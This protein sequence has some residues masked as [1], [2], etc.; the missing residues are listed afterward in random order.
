MMQGLEKIASLLKLYKLK[1]S[2]YVDKQPNDTSARYLSFENAVIKWYISILEFQARVVS[3]LWKGSFQQ[4]ARNTVKTEDF[5]GKLDDIMKAD[6]E[7]LLFTNLLDKEKDDRTRGQQ[8]MQLEQ[9]TKLQQGIV[10]ALDTTRKDRVAD[11]DVEQGNKLMH[12]LSNDYGDHKNFNPKRVPGTCEWFLH[13]KE[14]LEWRDATDSRLLWVS[15]GP[16][17]G[18]SVLSRCLI[19]ERHVCPRTRDSTTCY[20]FFRDGQAERETGPNAL[21]AISHQLLKQRPR[22]NLVRYLLPRFEV[23]GDKLGGM[24]SEL[25]DSMLEILSDPTTGEVVWILDALDECTESERERL[26]ECLTEIYS[27]EAYQNNKNIKL[28]TL[29]TSRQYHDIEMRFRRLRGLAGYIQ[30]DGDEKSHEIRQEI[31]LVIEYAV[32]R[33][34]SSLSEDDQEKV[35]EHLRNIPHRTYLWLHLILKEI[36]HKIVAYSTERRIASTIKKLPTSV[37]EAYER[38]LERSTDQQSARKILQIMIAA[39]RAL[40]VS[41]MNVALALALQDRCS[42]YDALDRPSD[43]EFKSSVKQI[44]GLFISVVDQKVYLLH[45]TAR[46]FLLCQPELAS[47]GWQQSLSLDSAHSLLFRI[48][49]YLLSFSEVEISPFDISDPVYSR[50]IW[51]EMYPLWLDGQVFL[52]YAAEAWVEHYHQMEEK[53]AKDLIEVGLELCSTSLKKPKFWWPM[54]MN[55][56]SPPSENIHVACGIGWHAVVE[57]MVIDGVDVN[58]RTHEGKRCPLHMAACSD[59]NYAVVKLLVDWGADVNAEDGSGRR[60]LHSACSNNALRVAELLL[61]NGADVDAASDFGTAL[62][63]ACTHNSEGMV[64]LLLGRGA[65]INLGDSDMNFPLVVACQ[66]GN[67]MIA[68]HLINHGADINVVDPSYGTALTTACSY[69]KEAIVRLLLQNEADI[70]TTRGTRR[71]T[72]L[73]KACYSEHESIVRTPVATHPPPDSPPTARAGCCESNALPTSGRC[74]VRKPGACR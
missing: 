70:E 23:H 10:E 71:P 11:Y 20:F 47:H 28:K 48:C 17:C 37:Y 67:V 46:E 12:S 19:D 59:Q 38:I 60:P 30:L 4:V 16:G 1:V 57:R 42:S 26:L 2:L 43:Q 3:H 58:L 8:Y 49:V 21:K 9:Q 15:A 62:C 63:D 13:S 68:Q 35:I 64:Q 56:R 24:F 73:L 40:T 69:G 54:A 6:T 61:D 18:K 74:N 33:V 50:E 53:S 31:N 32:P 41:E 55:S 27:S 39:K 25:W 44:C 7:C 34:A 29:I 5:Q 72:A 65:K 51:E 52:R 22:S 45:Q 66:K 14:F 36:E